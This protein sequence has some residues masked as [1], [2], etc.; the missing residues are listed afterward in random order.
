MKKKI[1]IEETLRGILATEVLRRD[2]RNMLLGMRSFQKK[3]YLGS[4][5]IFYP[6]LNREYFIFQTNQRFVSRQGETSAICAI[7]DIGVQAISYL[8]ANH[9]SPTGPMVKE[10]YVCD[11]FAHTMNLQ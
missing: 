2:W 8:L 10:V 11:I 4:V 9:T 5:T 7:S 3:K 1:F 6:Y